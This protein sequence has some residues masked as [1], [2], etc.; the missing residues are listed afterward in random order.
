MDI[1]KPRLTFWQIWNMSFGFLGIWGPSTTLTAE[2]F[3]TRIRGAAN[4][5]VWATAYLV[6]FVL[7][8]FVTAALQ[9]STGSFDLAFLCIPVLMIAMAVGVWLLVPEHAGRG[10]DAII[11]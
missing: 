5:V 8:P 3:P 9:Q 7:W 1:E 10:L 11:A 4:G 2:V 6:G